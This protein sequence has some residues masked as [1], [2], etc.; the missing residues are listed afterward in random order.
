MGKRLHDL[1]VGDKILTVCR[2]GQVRSVCLA[3]LLSDSGFHSHA[4]GLRHTRALII[5]CAWADHVFCVDYPK[6]IQKRIG[7]LTPYFTVIPTGPDI[8]ADPRSQSLVDLCTSELYKV[9]P[10]FR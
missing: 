7:L 10:S 1:K 5:G 9:L 6:K 3:R 4:V 2:M 8:W